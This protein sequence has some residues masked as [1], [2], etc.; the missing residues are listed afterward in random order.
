MWLDV[1]Q[2]A[3]VLVVL[4]AVAMADAR[5]KERLLDVALAVAAMVTAVAM[6]AEDMV[7]VVVAPVAMV[8]AVGVA[9]ALDSAA[10]WVP[11]VLTVVLMARVAIA[12]LG[13][14][15]LSAV[16]SHNW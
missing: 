7:I 14:A 10:R 1:A 16:G 15:P 2:V 9:V 11:E 5:A 4:A 12:D 8:T 6:I 13:S 3:V